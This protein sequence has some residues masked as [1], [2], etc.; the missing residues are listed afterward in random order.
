[1]EEA[2]IDGH[3]AFLSE[4]GDSNGLAEAMLRM[5]RAPNLAQMGA[6]GR[7]IV[8]DKFRIEQTWQ[9]YYELFLSLGAK[10]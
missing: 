10:P 6:V 7:Q 3:N 1:V 4:P 5:A 9:N 8:Q 2:A